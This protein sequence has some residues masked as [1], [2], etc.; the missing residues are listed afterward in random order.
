MAQSSSELVSL[1]SS[2]SSGSSSRRSSTRSMCSSFVL[3]SMFV[4]DCISRLWAKATA[5]PSSVKTTPLFQ[6]WIGDSGLVYD[7]SP[8]KLTTIEHMDK[9]PTL[10]FQSSST[11]SKNYYY[12]I[13]QV[14][15]GW[16]FTT[17]K[18]GLPEGGLTVRMN[19]RRILS[20]RY[21]QNIRHARGWPMPGWVVRGGSSLGR[22][23]KG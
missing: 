23:Q 5:L 8:Y 7:A 11:I 10:L 20:C 12:Q 18:T 21:F 9:G 6:L 16:T 13:I 2:L 19:E 22:E 3:G 17:T 14:E 4:W 1:M 15:G